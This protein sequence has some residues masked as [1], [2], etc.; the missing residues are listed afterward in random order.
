MWEE[1]G[2]GKIN[3]GL[4]ITGRCT[5]GYH[6]INTVFQSIGLADIIQFTEASTFR[7]TCTHQ[8]LPCDESN[9]AYKAYQLLR[10]YAKNKTPLHIHIK[11]KY[12]Y[13]GW[14]SRRKCRWSCCFTRIK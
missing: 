13:G 4:A 1:K 2:C 9:L 14:V 8:G 6:T 11:K 12:T 10:T 3:L 7:L 5:N